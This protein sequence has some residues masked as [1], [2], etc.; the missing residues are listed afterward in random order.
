M[1]ESLTPALVYKTQDNNH[2]YLLQ[3]WGAHKHVELT[4]SWSREVRLTEGEGVGGQFQSEPHDLSLHRDVVSMV[5]IDTVLQTP[6]QGQRKYILLL[7]C[8]ATRNVVR[9][10]ISVML[11]WVRG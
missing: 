1:K 9:Y 11:V 10:I 5:A 3:F 8:A 4:C 6:A 2:M 7:Q